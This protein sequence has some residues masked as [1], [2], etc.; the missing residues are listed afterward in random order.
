MHV[1]NTCKHQAHD[2]YTCIYMHVYKYVHVQILWWLV[3][4][5]CV[6]QVLEGSNAACPGCG[7]L[8]A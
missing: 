3:C 7:R 1:Y 5:C 8:I 6:K 4:D 2:V